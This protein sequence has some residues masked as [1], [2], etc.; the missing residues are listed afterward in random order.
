MKRI[1]TLGILLIL[2]IPQLLV[3]QCNLIFSAEGGESIQVT[4]DGEL[5]NPQLEK[6]VRVA[7]IAPGLHKARIRVQVSSAQSIVLHENLMLENGMEHYYN[8]KRNRKNEYVCRIYN[9]VPI[10]PIP[11]DPLN[12]VTGSPIE[13]S[14][15]PNPLPVNPNVGTLPPSGGNTTTMSTQTSTNISINIGTIHQTPAP[16]QPNSIASNPLQIPIPNPGV[17]QPIYVPG[18]NGPCG[19][20]MPVPANQ[21]EQ[22]KTTIRTKSFEDSKV[23]I[24]KQVINNNCLTVSQVREIMNLFSFEGTKLDFAKY[25]YQFTYDLNNYYLLNDA[26]TFESSITELDE[27][28]ASRPRPMPMNNSS[29]QLPGYNGPYG[30]LMPMNESAFQQAVNSIRSKS[31]EDS[32]LTIAKQL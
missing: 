21:F 17:P 31:F 23:T 29:Y 9:V 14:I 18:Y 4:I 13:Q 24:A 1:I 19:C 3:A 2:F 20:P 25:A 26:F 7:G 11:L 10:P 6:Q 15:N 8:I 22:M 27:Y 16:S 28:I 12:P 5:M 30:C 32:K